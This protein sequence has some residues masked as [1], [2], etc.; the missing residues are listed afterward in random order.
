MREI[1]HQLFQQT[2]TAYNVEE[3]EDIDASGEENPFLDTIEP[4]Q[5]QPLLPPPSHLPALISTLPTLQRP[6]IVILDSFDLFALHPRQ[7][8]LY[9]LLDTVQ[10]CRAGSGRS[11]LAVIGVTSRLDTTNLLE[12]RVKS[13]F[14][15]R[16]LRTSH[17]RVLNAWSALVQDVLSTPI[18]AD[19][20]NPER[21][22]TWQNAWK[23]NIDTF[24]T[25][26]AVGTLLRE[27]FA[28]SKDI[29]L[30]RHLLVSVHTCELLLKLTGE[31][32]GPCSPID[33]IFAF[34]F[35]IAS[36]GGRICPTATS[37]TRGTA[38]YVHSPTSATS[39]FISSYM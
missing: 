20:D 13:R 26:D 33:R 32:D 37:T 3:N 12:K 34:S 4:E 35:S 39:Y 19:E 17:P 28:V 9:C 24:S 25:D 21:V 23:T 5:N 31:T 1:A 27:V 18:S 22:E 30:L 6:T 15:G 2:G 7:A 10:S 8:L 29:R 38:W 16:I 36:F 11:A 14:S